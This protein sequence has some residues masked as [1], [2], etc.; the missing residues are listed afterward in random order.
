M[1]RCY[2]QLDVK[3]MNLGKPVLEQI[4]HTPRCAGGTFRSTG[5]WSRVRL[6]F[7]RKKSSVSMNSEPDM[8]TLPD[9]ARTPWTSTAS[10]TATDRDTTNVTERPYGGAFNRLGVGLQTSELLKCGSWM[11]QLA[12]TDLEN[13]IPT[14]CEH[15][16]AARFQLQLGQANGASIVREI[17]MAQHDP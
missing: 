5:T 2:N 12:G 10:I 14:Y 3:A 7:R 17:E 15:K 6:P 11:E 13:L 1:L 9:W 4:V 8:S 16:L